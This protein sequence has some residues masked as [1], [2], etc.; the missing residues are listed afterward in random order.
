M[1]NDFLKDAAEWLDGDVI[2]EHAGET[3]DRENAQGGE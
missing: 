2:G 1:G 3:H